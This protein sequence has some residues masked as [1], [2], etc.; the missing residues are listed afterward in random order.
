MSEQSTREKIWRTLSYSIPVL[1]GVFL[2]FVPFPHTTAIRE[3]CF[4]LALVLSLVL[5][6]SK[7][8]N[9]V[10]KT[11]LTYPL[12]LFFL[13]SLLSIFWSLN[14]ENSIDD[15]RK[16]LLNHIILYFLLINAFHSMGRLRALAWIVVLSAA[17]F[18]ATGMAYYYI[19]SEA[20]IESV[21]F[22]NIL[23]SVNVS[24]ELPVNFIGTLT[25]FAVILCLHLYFQESGGYRRV[26]TMGCLIPVG[27][28]TLF[29]QSRGTFFAL[30]VVLTLLVFIKAKKSAFLL[31]LAVI[32]LIVMATPLKDRLGGN[33]HNLKERLYINY[34]TCDVIKD[35]PLLGIG[36]G[37]QTFINDIDKESYVRQVPSEQRPAEIYTPHNWLL[38]IAV[39]L[40]LIGLMLFC[41]ILLVFV[42]MCWEII[43][44]PRDRYIRD[45][46]L[47]TAVAFVGYFIIGM[48]EPV[49]LFRASAAVF[50][51]ILAIITILW[52]LNQETQGGCSQPCDAYC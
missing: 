45:W 27:M 28:A 2:F 10:F 43:R 33:C 24:T 46:G 5:I 20:S 11:P 26:L 30:L 21:R 42:R 9:F 34:V 49:F 3:I 32:L 12:I 51:I 29:T 16:H 44:H 31:L 7:R 41:Y 37:M 23:N 52:H 19:I 35:H 36:F 8:Q 25:I 17:F 48:A 14:V 38:D 50:F 6:L 22:G 47:S 15:V 1:V 18:S 39:R 40:G 4:Y 13:W